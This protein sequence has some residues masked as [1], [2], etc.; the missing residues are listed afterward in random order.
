MQAAVGRH[1][2]D[3]GAHGQLAHA[4]EDVAAGGVDVE[5]CAGLEDGFGGGGKVG[6]S[7]EELGHGFGNARS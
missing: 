4:E 1:A 7:A 2:V 5:V 6:R 3:R